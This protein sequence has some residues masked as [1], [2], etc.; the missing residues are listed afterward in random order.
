M[1]LG[2]HER[3][4][5]SC[6]TS[7]DNGRRVENRDSTGA[8]LGALEGIAPMSVDFL[9]SIIDRV[10]HP[11]F[12][13]DRSFCWVLLNQE[14]CE[15]VGYPREAML[16]HTDYD[17]F[18]KNEADFFRQKDIEMF[19]SGERVVI[20]EEPITDAQG[21]V[22]VLAT[23]KVPLR[24]D[25]GDVTHLV[26]II[27]DIT[28]LKAAEEALRYAKVELERRVIER[29]AAL[30]AAQAALVRKERLA[31]LGQLAGGLAHQIRNPLGAITN[32]AYVLQRNVAGA[33]EESSRAAAIILEEVW[34]AN[35]II[36]DLLDYARVRPPVRRAVSLDAVLD[37]A[38]EAQAIPPSISVERRLGEL[39]R[40]AADEDQLRD[41]LDNL[42]RN[43]IEA[44]PAGGKLTITAAREG[45]VVRVS[46]ADTG[47]G[48]ADE[49]REKLF[50]PLATTKPLGLGLGLSTTRA[51]IQNQGGA[52]SC[53]SPKG[54]GARFDVRLP[55][56]DAV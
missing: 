15:M 50:E 17:F 37:R 19:A 6:R 33:G 45:D 38:L 10:A 47:E 14:F 2:R 31:L 16:G 51:L 30:E 3:R 48:I 22:H 5:R 26:G 12:V 13:K 1:P 54:E 23:T 44:M 42:L 28:R 52:V 41:A 34:H 56:F 43:A 24:S 55:V 20:E 7:C 11:I 27:H 8:G 36:T 18:P 4:L 35:R 40:V 9:A 46:I 53:V 25:A 49:I 32:A 39:P 21:N 29:T